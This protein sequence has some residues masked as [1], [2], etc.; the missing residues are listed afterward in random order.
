MCLL[1]TVLKVSK[2]L[3]GK[4]LPAM[5]ETQVRSLGQ[6]GPLAKEMANLLQSSYLE[7]SIDRGAWWAIQS[8]GLQE[9]D[10]T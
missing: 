2:W 7:N 6:E 8:M 5:Q 3:S 1:K 10:T 4:N 9:S